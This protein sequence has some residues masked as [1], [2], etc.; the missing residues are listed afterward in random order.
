MF[1]RFGIHGL[2]GQTFM[3]TLGGLAGGGARVKDPEGFELHEHRFGSLIDIVTAGR[4]KPAH[5][6]HQDCN[7]PQMTVM[8]G[9][10]KSNQYKGTGVFSHAIKLSHQLQD[11]VPGGGAVVQY[12]EYKGVGQQEDLPN[13]FPDSVILH[14]WYAKGREVMVYDDT[15]HLHSAPNHIH[16][17]AVWRFM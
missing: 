4:L 17:A 15:W 3:K 5:S 8:L 9:F 7:L 1:E 16:R 2:D 12:D 11:Q 13:P 10:P 14:P 6:W